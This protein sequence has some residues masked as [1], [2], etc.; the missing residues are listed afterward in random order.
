M[1]P[2]AQLILPIGD[3]DVS[4]YCPV[5]KAGI[6]V[7]GGCVGCPHVVFN[8]M[9]NPEDDDFQYIGPKYY[10]IARKAEKEGRDP[11]EAVIEVLEKRPA[12][13]VFAI[14]VTDTTGNQPTQTTL[15]TAIDYAPKGPDAVSRSKKKK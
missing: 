8:H 13:F 2:I 9:R 4:I 12:A 7:E 14:L 10:R 11:L 5:C 3:R 6:F 15:T 1:K